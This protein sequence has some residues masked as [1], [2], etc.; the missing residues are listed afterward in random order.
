MRR[1]RRKFSTEF[2][3]QVVDLVAR[4]E[5]TVAEAA[6]Q[7][8]IT[9]NTIYAWRRELR[10]QELDAAV[11][12]APRTN[13]AK[14]GVDPRYVREL[15]MKLREANEKL[16]EMYIVVEGLKKVGLV[17]GHTKSVSSFV[18]TQSTLARYK[19]RVG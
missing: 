11:A 2:K 8:D 4:G 18:A 5:Q 16:G 15:E 3:K 9:T 12:S 13:I 14:Q 6:R 10:D 7:F 17:P 19:R 1:S